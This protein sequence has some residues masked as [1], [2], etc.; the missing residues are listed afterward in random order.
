MRAI[1]LLAALTLGG[2]AN[3]DYAADNYGNTPLTELDHDGHPYRVFDKPSQNRLMITSSIG[4]AIGGGLIR[5]AT[6]GLFSNHP[7]EPV[8][9]AAAA[10]YLK[11]T[12]RACTLQ[13]GQLI[14]QPQW[15]FRYSCKS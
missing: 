3:L 13:T 5:G 15:E 10:E 12:N 2:C 4:S 1:L 9:Q 11:S 14:A 6:F 7:S 8:M